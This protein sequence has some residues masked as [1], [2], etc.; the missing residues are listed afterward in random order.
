MSN[1]ESNLMVHAVVSR[2]FSE[3][4]YLAY[5]SGRS[6][7]VVID[8]GFEPQLILDEIANRRLIPQAI[9][10][11]HGHLDHIAGNEALKRCWPNIP[12]VIGKEDAYKLTDAN[13]NLSL[14]YGFEVLSPP[15]DVELSEGATFRAAGC[16]F[17]VL[18]TPG[19]SAG[20][21]IFVW[22]G[23]AR[24]IIF[25]GDVLFAGGV[26]R[27]D[28]P[29]GCWEDLERSIHEKFFTLPDEA[30]IYPGHGESTTVGE[31]RRFN[32]YVGRNASR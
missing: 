21:V 31:E 14:P 11:T 13:A 10:C 4:T 19:H 30:T 9:L 8:P 22:K 2:P 5:L 1:V 27:W 32:P 28:T 23:N 18:E 25:G 6:E 29:D 7:C 16:S 24:T 20:H 26:G 3:N 12:L 15:A 17:E